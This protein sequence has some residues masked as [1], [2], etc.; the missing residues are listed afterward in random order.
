VK[1]HINGLVAAAASSRTVSA[2]AKN[3]NIDEK[4]QPGVRLGSERAISS[5]LRLKHQ[6]SGEKRIGGGGHAP[7]SG[8]ASQPLAACI[9]AGSWRICR[10]RKQICEKSALKN[11]KAYRI[12]SNIYFERQRKRNKNLWR[13]GAA[14]HAYRHE[15]NNIAEK[16]KQSTR[17]AAGWACRAGAYRKRSGD[18]CSPEN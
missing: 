15:K 9:G 16:R 2:A 1:N 11:R 17:L 10:R 5:I 13:S 6:Q 7:A 8:Q 3:S 18:T 14:C 4:N 12:A